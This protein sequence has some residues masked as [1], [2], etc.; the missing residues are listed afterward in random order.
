MAEADQAVVG[1]PL[2]LEVTEVE[3]PVTVRVAIHVR[4]PVVTV[5]AMYDAP[6]ISLEIAP[7][8]SCIAVG[9]LT[10]ER[11][12]PTDLIFTYTIVL[13]PKTYPRSNSPFLYTR[14]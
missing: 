1:I 4:Y 12:A 13:A 2:I 14:V 3:L 10:P 7:A 5:S 11:V 8:V 6:S 9:V